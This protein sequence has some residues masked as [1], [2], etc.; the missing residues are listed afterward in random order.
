M[1][2]LSSFLARYPEVNLEVATNV[3]VANMIRR[4]ADVALRLVR[5]E[6]GDLVISRLGAMAS[7]LYAARDYLA[8]HPFEANGKNHKVVVWDDAFA[9][10][11]SA[12]WLSQHLPDAEPALST[13]SLQSQ[14]AACHAGIGLAVLPCFLADE[15]VS[16]AN[17]GRPKVAFSEDIWLVVHREIADAARVRVVVE[18]LRSVIRESDQKLAGIE[19]SASTGLS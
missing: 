15:D 5:P 7:G 8:E 12:R 10:L 14:L 4:E 9:Q 2:K 17:V 11:A 18:H 3:S 13:T 19:E 1:P 16:L 6:A